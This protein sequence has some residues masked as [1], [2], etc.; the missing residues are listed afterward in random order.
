MGVLRS[1][2]LFLQP[3]MAALATALWWLCECTVTDLSVFSCDMLIWKV[4]L[5][6]LIHGGSSFAVCY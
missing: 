3:V 2:A 4:C 6:L 5:L 1:P